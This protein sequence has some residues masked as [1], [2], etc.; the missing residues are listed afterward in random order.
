MEQY[1]LGKNDI[2]EAIEDLDELHKL[3]QGSSSADPLEE[4]D[5]GNGT[6]PRPII[7]NKNI[8]ADYKA[9]VIELLR[10]YIDCFA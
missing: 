4:L 1:R 8:K 10:E 2:C 3:G 5:I 9:K 7:V 6:T